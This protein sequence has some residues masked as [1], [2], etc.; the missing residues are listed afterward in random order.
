MATTGRKLKGIFPRGGLPLQHAART[1]AASCGLDRWLR[2]R[3]AEDAGVA[4]GEGLG[5][6]GW[7]KLGGAVDYCKGIQKEEDTGGEDFKGPCPF[8]GR[9]R[10]K[11][12]VRLARHK[13]LH[14]L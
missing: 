14:G 1:G 3:E 12:M 10:A 9:E 7:G 6:A 4:R 5:T 8:L 2:M 11:R 13:H